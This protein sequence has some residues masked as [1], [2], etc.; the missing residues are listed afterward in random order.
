MM[1]LAPSILAADFANLGAQIIEID[2]AG[3]Q[4]VH[5]DVMDGVCVPSISF[6]FPIIE[7]I[8]PLT[9]RFFDVHLMIVDPERYI[10]EFAKAGADGITIHVEAC[11]CIPETIDRIK[12]LGLKAGISLHPQTPVSEIMP[13]LDSVDKVLIMTVNTGFGG[14]KYID[15]CTQKIIDIRKAIQE[16]GLDVDI[17]IDGGVNKDNA[18]Y[19]IEA[20]ANILV[21][22]SSVFRG[23]V[24]ENVAYFLNVLKK[25]ENQ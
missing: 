22:G 8:R 25:Y 23:E 14:Q 19:I 9:R 1:I 12:A 24:K 13:Y 18:A 15:A 17:E 4:H 3:A 2:K 10:D 21:S 11:K 5:I 16:K 7:S 6:G 20:G